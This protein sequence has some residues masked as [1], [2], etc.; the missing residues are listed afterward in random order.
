MINIAINQSVFEAS[1]TKIQPQH[2]TNT[3]YSRQS[4]EVAPT[5]AALLIAKIQLVA[6]VSK[7]RYTLGD[8]LQQHVAATRRFVCAGEFCENLCLRNIILSLQQVAKNQIRQNLCDLLLRQNSVAETKIFTKILL[9]T[10]S[11][12][13]LRRVAVT[14][15]CN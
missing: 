3:W 2:A 15:C 9:Y 8:K 11:D 12:L 4:R 6:Q 13:S 7:G 5:R 1:A 14:C 10:R